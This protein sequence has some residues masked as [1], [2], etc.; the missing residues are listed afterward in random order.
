MHNLYTH[1]LFNFFVVQNFKKLKTFYIK[2]LEN[3]KWMNK[4]T[5]QY[6]IVVFQ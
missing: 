5:K 3:V 6:N 4:H 1:H 2:K